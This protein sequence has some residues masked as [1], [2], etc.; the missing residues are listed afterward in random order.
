MRPVVAFA[1]AVGLQQQILP[2]WRRTFQ[3]KYRSTHKR[4]DGIKT[5]FHTNN[6]DDARI[7]AETGARPVEQ[8]HEEE[9]APEREDPAPAE[10]EEQGGE[11][12]AAEEECS[13]AA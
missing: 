8:E 7:F 10:E 1:P 3:Y 4:D 2:L 12:A 6:L 9:Q 13:E 11:P 5:T